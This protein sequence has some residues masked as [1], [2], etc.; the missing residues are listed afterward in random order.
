MALKEKALKRL[1]EKLGAAGIPFSLGGS[2][3]LVQRQIAEQYHSFDVVVPPESGAAADRVLSRLGLRS[4][5]REDAGCFRGEYHFDGADVTLH[6]GMAFPCGARAVIS[7]P[8]WERTVPVL[9]AAVPLGFAED[10]LVWSELSGAAGQAEALRRY[11]EAHPSPCP[12][13]FRACIE[14]PLPPEAESLIASLSSAG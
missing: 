3:M 9:G 4:E 10:W 6:A 11:F 14:G 2:W 12:E 1:T 13:R 7:S 8:A 5:A